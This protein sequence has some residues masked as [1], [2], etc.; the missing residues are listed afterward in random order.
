MRLAFE[1]TTRDLYGSG[2][3]ITFSG[4]TTVSVLILENEIWC[5][6]IGDSRGIIGRVLDKDNMQVIEL[7][8]DHK[9]DNPLEFKRVMEKGGR[10]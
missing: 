7:S 4:A 8:N 3:D 6:N 5:S 1:R 9:P 2:I 10:V